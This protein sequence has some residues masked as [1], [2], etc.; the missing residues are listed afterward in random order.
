MFIS[1]I[2]GLFGLDIEEGQTDIRKDTVENNIHIAHTEH[3]E[4]MTRNSFRNIYTSF[5]TGLFSLDIRKG[6][7]GISVALKDPNE[8]HSDPLTHSHQS[9]NLKK[10]RYSN[11]Y[12]SKPIDILYKPSYMHWKA[13]HLFVWHV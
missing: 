5:L 9:E 12:V 11:V 4:N 6:C 3:S 10:Q 13:M 8:T 2:K 1:L 7:T